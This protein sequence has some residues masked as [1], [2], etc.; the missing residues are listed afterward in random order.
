MT[1][2]IVNKKY[3]GREY[4][5]ELDMEQ[6]NGKPYGYFTKFIRDNYDKSYGIENAKSYNIKVTGHK[7]IGCYAYLTVVAP[8]DSNDDIWDAINQEEIENW[9]DDYLSDD[10]IEIDDFEFV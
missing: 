9:E 6:F 4:P 8:S 1:K 3:H 10:D 2:I 5:E 7:R